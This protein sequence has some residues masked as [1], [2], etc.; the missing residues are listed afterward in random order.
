MTTPKITNEG[1]SIQ[2]T[3]GGLASGADAV[4]LTT[5]TL[6]EQRGGI[7]DDHEQPDP[8]QER[9]SVT[10]DGAPIIPLAWNTDIKGELVLD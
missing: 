5:P 9:L 10:G 8:L 2:V 7:R 4:V 3:N 1:L 6:A